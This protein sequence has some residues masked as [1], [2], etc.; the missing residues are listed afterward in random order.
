MDFDRSAL[1]EEEP[2][3]QCEGDDDRDSVSGGPEIAASRLTEPSGRGAAPAFPG[4]TG[5]FRLVGSVSKR[6]GPLRRLPL[7]QQG[8]GG[9]SRMQGSPLKLP[10]PRLALCRRAL[11]VG[12]GPG[13]RMPARR[14]VPGGGDTGRIQL[15][16]PCLGHGAQG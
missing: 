15:L 5:N 2:T 8:L 14:G 1:M 9:T 16:T 7:C 3:D 13:E 12:W 11:T 4:H 6:Y 10:R